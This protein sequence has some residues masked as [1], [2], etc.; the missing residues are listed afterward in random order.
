MK[1][2]QGKEIHTPPRQMRVVYTTFNPITN[3]CLLPEC[4]VKRIEV[5]DECLALWIMRA[6][7]GCVISGRISYGWVWSLSLVSATDVHHMCSCWHVRFWSRFRHASASVLTLGK[8]RARVLWLGYTLDIIIL[9]WSDFRRSVVEWFRNA[10]RDSEHFLIR[11]CM[12]MSYSSLFPLKWVMYK[13][14]KKSRTSLVFQPLNGTPRLLPLE[15]P[16][17]LDE[18]TAPYHL[19]ACVWSKKNGWYEI[20]RLKPCPLELTIPFYMIFER[21]ITSYFYHMESKDI[22]KN[23]I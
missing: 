20:N 10:V 16:R 11:W 12:F 4:W 14:W 1:V 13:S 2:P 22:T 21:K 3:N 18:R 7:S 17:V 9:F 8:L 19:P 5:S 23:I 15:V 6:R